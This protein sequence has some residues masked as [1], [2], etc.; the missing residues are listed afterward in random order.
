[1]HLTAG[2]LRLPY[3][4]RADEL[5]K[6]KEI[7]PEDPEATIENLTPTEFRLYIT[8]LMGGP[9]RIRSFGVGFPGEPPGYH[10]AAAADF[11]CDRGHL[12]RATR[13]RSPLAPSQLHDTLCLA[14]TTMVPNS[15]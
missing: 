6:A 5:A 12:A 9:S 3:W 4:P 14:C 15:R 7:V 8:D 2:V 13:A 1:M 11:Q 10:A